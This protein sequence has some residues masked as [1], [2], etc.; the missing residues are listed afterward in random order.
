MEKTEG[1][2][3]SSVG[4]EDVMMDERKHA[5]AK[6]GEDDKVGGIL[7]PTDRREVNCWYL[8]DWCVFANAL[9]RRESLDTFQ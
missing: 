9:S 1:S 7:E 4:V 5:A 3:P 8:Y 2:D 6:A